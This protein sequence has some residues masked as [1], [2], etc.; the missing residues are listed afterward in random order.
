MV[1]VQL[2]KSSKRISLART[3]SW[4]PQPYMFFRNEEDLA[5]GCESAAQFTIVKENLL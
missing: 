4:D 2:S 1:K 3:S 5:P